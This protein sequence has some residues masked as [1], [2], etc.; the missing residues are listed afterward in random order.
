M[1]EEELEKREEALELQEKASWSLLHGRR[2]RLVSSARPQG[3]VGLL[4]MVAGTAGWFPPHG[5]RDCWL[6]LRTA[7]GWSP[8][9]GHRNRW[10]VSSAQLQ[11]PVGVLRTATGTS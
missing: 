6:V 10:L 5:C 9:H 7:A 8:P 3:P 4:R 11:G 1:K 2:D